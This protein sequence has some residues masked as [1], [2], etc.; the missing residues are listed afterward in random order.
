[1][2]RLTWGAPDLEKQAT[3]AR[4]AWLD[5]KEQLRVNQEQ[6]DR[7]QKETDAA[8]SKANVKKQ[9]LEQV[10]ALRQASSMKANLAS[11]KFRAKAKAMTKKREDELEEELKKL[12]EQGFQKIKE[13][14]V[15]WLQELGPEEEL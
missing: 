9:E 1:M 8:E 10:K 7:V 5:R 3:A 2:I 15:F 11:A 6:C 4:Q 12:R 14:E 13:K